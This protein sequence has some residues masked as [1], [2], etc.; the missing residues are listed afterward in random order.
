MTK[1]QTAG[2]DYIDVLVIH[3]HPHGVAG[4]VAV[5]IEETLEA[6]HDVVRAGKVLYL[7]GS[8]MFAWQFAELQLTAQLHGWTKFVAMQN[9]YNLIYREEE[10]ENES[11]LYQD[12]GR[13]HS[14]VAAGAGRAARLLS[15]RIRSG[16]DPSLPRTGP[17]A[18]CGRDAGCPAPPAQI[19]TCALTHTAPTFGSDRSPQDRRIRSTAWYTVPRHCV[20]SVLWSR[21]FPLVMGLGSTS[22]ATART[23][24]FAS[25]SATMPM[26]DSIRAVHHRLTASRLPDAVPA[27]TG[28]TRRPPRS[29]HMTYVRA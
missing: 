4:H 17:A 5:P 10:Q 3:R 12:E 25:F 26:S 8:T 7:G 9:H 21:K 13:A 14:L 27:V 18:L 2:H 16:F 29:R 15:G 20:R 28:T 1:A 19:R 6:L 23:A 22:S 11:L 24:L